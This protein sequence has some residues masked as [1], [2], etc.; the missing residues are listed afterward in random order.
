M[1]RLVHVSFLFRRS[2]IGI[3]LL[4][5][6]RAKSV[7]LKFLNTFH[8][9]VRIKHLDS[10]KSLFDPHRIFAPSIIPSLISIGKMS[11]VSKYNQPRGLKPH[12]PMQSRHCYFLFA[13]HGARCDNASVFFRR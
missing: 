8:F 5:L 11:K 1:F 6:F 7:S 2:H 9:V 10:L 13:L 4:T 3:K 12:V